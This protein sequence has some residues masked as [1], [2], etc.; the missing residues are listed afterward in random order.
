MIKRNI[1]ILVLLVLIFSCQPTS[2]DSNDDTESN[3]DNNNKSSIATLSL[4]TLSPG[5]LIPD[6]S[7]NILSYDVNDATSST[8]ITAAPTDT[9]A[10]MGYSVNGSAYINLEANVATDFNLHLGYNT[11]FIKVTAEDGSYRDYQLLIDVTL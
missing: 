9:K 7:S 11:V 5:T 8:L 10:T 4:L 6:F 2:E 1:I 3:N